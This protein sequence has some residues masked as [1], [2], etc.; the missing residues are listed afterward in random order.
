MIVRSGQFAH[1][2]A[3]ANLEDEGHT[4]RGIVISYTMGV[5]RLWEG[6]PFIRSV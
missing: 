5:L 4:L 3:D 2:F 6:D 1:E